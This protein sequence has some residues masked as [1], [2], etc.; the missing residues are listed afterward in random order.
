M[1]A[2][3]LGSDFL[4]DQSGT[5]KPIEINTNVAYDMNN[6]LEIN[7]DVWNYD[8]LSRFLHERGIK[9]I[10]AEQNAEWALQYQDYID[11]IPI[12]YS[13]DFATEIDSEDILLFRVLYSDEAIVD[14]YCADKI[15][16]QNLVE[17][18]EYSLESIYKDSDG[19][20]HG[21]IVNIPDNGDY[22]NLI[23][24][25]RYPYYDT[26]VYP[27]FFKVS[28]QEDIER[29][30]NS[31]SFPADY[32]LSTMLYNDEVG[33]IT[34]G[35]GT[36]RE[37]LIR[38][39][40]IL[41]STGTELKSIQ[42]GS[43]SKLGTALGPVEYDDLELR[44]DYRS[45]FLT[46]HT[47]T[48][49]NMGEVLAEASDLV[50]MSDGSWK[51]ADEIQE[52]DFVKSLN[53]P[54]SGSDIKKHI[55]DLNIT[56]EELQEG[57]T[58][59]EAEV[60]LIRK[61]DAFVSKIHITFEDGTDWYDTAKSS[62]L[63][64]DPSGDGSMVFTT[65]DTVQPGTIVTLVD[66]SIASMPVYVQKVVQTVEETREQIVGYQL[67]LGGPYIFITREESVDVGYASIEHNLS[68]CTCTKQAGSTIKK[69]FCDCDDNGNPSCYTSTDPFGTGC[70][71][72]IRC[73]SPK[74]LPEKVQ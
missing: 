54:Y 41:V 33:T 71:L 31:D 19:S 58:Y 30:V 18:K 44:S 56:F 48:G 38:D 7:D 26:L 4:Y 49:A 46:K 51:R 1:R 61:T 40:N 16:F 13:K 70:R 25:Y 72:P 69:C 3:L 59:V 50:W 5:L 6:R 53:V 73:D 23:L 32:Y 21:E 42:I 68:L 12:E 15:E 65:L 2:V 74:D 8:N 57:S 20:V 43:Y 66:T 47:F 34:L 22:P 24:K 62:Y 29:I 45:M 36:K 14:S 63:M 9:K 55:G 37:R 39:L 11:D 28:S 27:K 17:G 35:D 60:N 67:S 52:G 10:V 64:Q